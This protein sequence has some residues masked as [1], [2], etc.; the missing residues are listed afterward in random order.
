MDWINWGPEAGAELS[1]GGSCDCKLN[2][3]GR[4]RLDEP[5]DCWFAAWRSW[6]SILTRRPSTWSLPFCGD[7]MRDRS[8][9]RSLAR[10]R[11]VPAM[12]KSQLV[13]SRPGLAAQPAQRSKACQGQAAMTRQPIPGAAAGRADRCRTRRW[14]VADRGAAL[15]GSVV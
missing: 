3:G 4:T 9:G 10:R 2:S 12:V 15:L 14:D 8:A 5:I 7:P 13:G 6:M 11:L 1:T